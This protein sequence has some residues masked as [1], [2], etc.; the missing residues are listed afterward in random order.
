MMHLQQLSMIFLLG[1]GVS[2]QCT[3][4][5]PSKGPFAGAPFLYSMDDES[6]GGTGM[7][8]A[9]F[10]AG[11]T[12]Y[13]PVT[14]RPDL[15]IGTVLAN[16]VS[17]RPPEINAISFGLD[18]VVAEAGGRAVLPP[19]RWATL[20]FAVSTSSKGNG[21]VI[22]T[23][24]RG[25]GGAAADVFTYVLPGSTLSPFGGVV[26]RAQDATEFLP[27]SGTKRD[28]DALDFHAPLYTMD[29]AFFAELQ[30]QPLTVYF[31]VSASTISL[32]PTS[33]W[34]GTSPSAATILR[35]S[36]DWGN[37]KWT[38][39]KVFLSAGAMELG[40]LD[41]ID[42]L[43]V[44]TTS[45]GSPVVLFSTTDVTREQLWVHF[46]GSSESAA[47]STVV[48]RGASGNPMGEDLG[49]ATRDDITALCEIDPTITQDVNFWPP[50]H[51]LADL[52]PM[53]FAMAWPINK[54]PLGIPIGL[55]ASAFVTC[56]GGTAYETL[57]LGWPSG[58][59]TP[60]VVGLLLE[61][62]G[63]SYIALSPIITRNVVPFFC[64]DPHR[65]GFSL[66]RPPF[67]T[68]RLTD[69]PLNLVWL[70]L[71]ASAGFVTSYPLQI[72][73]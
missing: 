66:D 5:G 49:L 1:A 42:A 21:G 22:T 11:A 44:D 15:D 19:E 7:K 17:G 65:G 10:G 31:S 55:E 45:S 47:A 36:W 72:H 12:T 6:S 9:G 62:P 37:S 24:A 57:T 8:C 23:E 71:D 40:Q 13:T 16:A 51:R 2:A 43:A 70:G 60:G 29:P 41:D 27:T 18:I 3:L 46:T 56:D 54:K 67:S 52:H 61:L 26:H 38:P 28:V 69:T 58:V 32:V 63:P 50:T 64:G 25:V 33:W 4:A 14:G 39:P 35:M 68:F 20:A 59:P 30:G 48:Y 53:R 73:L 34:A